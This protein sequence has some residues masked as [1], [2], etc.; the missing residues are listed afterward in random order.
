MRRFLFSIVAHRLQLSPSE[1]A[2]STLIASAFCIGIFWLL[3]QASLAFSVEIPARGGTYEE[4]LVGVPRFINPVLA[5]SDTDR[6]LVRLVY[7]GLLRETP[8]GD[9]VPDLAQTYEVSEDQKTYT[10]TLRDDIFF[11]DGEPVTAADVVFTV[12]LA[13]NPAIKSPRRANWEGVSVVAID[14]RTVMFTLRSPYAPFIENLSLGIIPRHLW[15]T[16]SPEEF[17][18]STLNT[19]PIGAGP[20]EVTR[21]RVSS[22]GVPTSIELAAFTKS[23]AVP[24]ISKLRFSFFQDAEA[25]HT[26][27]LEDRN[28]AGHSVLP[29]ELLDREVHEAIL[30]RIFAVFY[31]Q[32]RNDIFA[33]TAVRAALDAALDKESLVATLVDGYGS[34]LTGP[35]PPK[36]IVRTISA[37]SSDQR[38]SEAARL[39][40]AAGWTKGDDGVFMKKNKTTSKRLQFS[41]VTSNAPELKR[42]AE[43]VA[44]TWRQL[45]VEVD[46]QFFE[47]ND[48]QQEIIR[49]RKY[50]A[51]LFGEA[52]GRDLDLFAFWH[53]SQRNDP[54]LNIALYVNTAV[55][56]LL[57]EARTEQD[58][59]TRRARIESAAASIENEFAATFLY[60][61]HFVYAVPSAVQGLSLGTIT[62]PSDRFIGIENWYLS[63]E[64]VWPIFAR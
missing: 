25:L 38:L 24:Y 9:T 4:G 52:I 33:E 10:F 21:M 32:N 55:D 14:E 48:L 60:A 2:A 26:A 54:G 45:G 19:A 37:T 29:D 3:A 7:A 47:A 1:W 12:L 31:N 20:Y 41:L 51:L 8:S 58:P 49:P 64:R 40:A 42:A 16:V 6:D 46:T 36:E 63:T 44:A 18:F 62:M 57:S 15:E 35:L 13:Q 50:D 17:Q 61:P 11:H 23:H 43:E 39:L 30:G 59:A 22:S 34:V 27:L 28:L 5:V 53:S 56:A